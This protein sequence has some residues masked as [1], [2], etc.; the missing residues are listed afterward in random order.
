MSDTVRAD[1]TYEALIAAV[2]QA[3][4]PTYAWA[5]IPPEEGADGGQPGGNIRNAFLYDPSRVHLVDGTLQR[6]GTSSPAFEGSRKPLTARFRLVDGHGELEIV[7]VHLASKRHQNGL[8]APSRPGFDPRGTIRVEQAEVIGA[9]VAPLRESEVDYYVTGDFN[10][11]EFSDTLRA[12]TG[13]HSVNLVDG[14][15]A[16]LRFDYNHRGL[17]EALMHGVVAKRQLVDRTVEYEIL[18]AN[19]LQGTPP[20]RQGQK[21]SDHA[22][23]IARLQLGS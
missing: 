8:F 10:D 2:R 12:L 15:P 16:P 7:N 3:G 1:R 20:G 22:Y 18:H 21:P 23:V 13:D 5:D 9:H 19:A 17:S 4:G 11:F 14:V 6:L